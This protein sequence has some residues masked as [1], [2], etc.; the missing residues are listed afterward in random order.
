V[1]ARRTSLRIAQSSSARTRRLDVVSDDG[2]SVMS[3]RRV[4]GNGASME[5]DVEQ[6]A[7]LAQA[8]RL[9]TEAVVPASMRLCTLRL[10]LVGRIRIDPSSPIASAAV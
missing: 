6:G 4:A 3:A 8:L 2:E 7:V 1:E 10:T 5:R 9:E